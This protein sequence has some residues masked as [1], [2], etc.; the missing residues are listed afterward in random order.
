M[1]KFELF[2]K[3][4]MLKVRLAQNHHW[5]NIYWE[6]WLALQEPSLIIGC[7]QNLLK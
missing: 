4:A 5:K 3:K 6:K 7:Y 2:Q 1:H